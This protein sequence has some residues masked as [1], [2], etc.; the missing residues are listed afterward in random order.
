MNPY[1][2]IITIPLVSAFMLSTTSVSTQ[3]ET[4]Y[5]SNISFGAKGGMG[6]SKVFFNPTV[7]QKLLPGPTF[8]MTF[9]YIEENHFGLIAEINYN[10]RGWEEN[11]EDAP[12]SYQRRL[13]YL[14]F[15][16]LAHIYF[17]KRGRFFFNAGPEFSIF[18]NEKTSSN[19]NPTE[20]SV[21][22]EFPATNRM[23][24]QMLQEV[25]QKFDYGISAG[26]G[27]EVNLNKR[28]SLYL[29]AR[30]YFGLGNI[31]PAKRTD[32]FNA[33]NQLTISTTIG[34]WFRFK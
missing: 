12:Y 6:F 28:N 22:P 30:F 14:S 17:G 25:T 1:F 3:A 18:L 34:Y 31:F 20:I 15:P 27:G 23:N 9:R 7:H 4:H 33:S 5:S 11:F 13:D 2:K 24:L 32:T 29:E 21:L 19:F 26:L 10:T 16:V 8:G